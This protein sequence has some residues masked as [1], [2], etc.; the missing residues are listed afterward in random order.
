[1]GKTL[2]IKVPDLTA[3]RGRL[4]AAA[5]RC[6]RGIFTPP[7]DPQRSRLARR[8]SNEVSIFL[9]ENNTVYVNHI[10]L[11]G[12]KNPSIVINMLW[13]AMQLAA[14]REGLTLR[15]PQE[16]AAPAIVEGQVQI[17]APP[18]GMENVP[19]TRVASMQDEPANGTAH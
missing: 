19:L 7:A 17:P 12:P 4:R 10:C 15:M 2:T 18:P 6:I 1:M 11:T 5:E 9:G 13:Q 14:M 3:L 16:A 8:Y